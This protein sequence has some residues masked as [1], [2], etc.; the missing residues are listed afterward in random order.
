MVSL[1]QEYFTVDKKL[2][3]K[4]ESLIGDKK[5]LE[6]ILQISDPTNAIGQVVATALFLI[7]N[8]FESSKKPSYHLIADTKKFW[9]PLANNFGM[10]KVRYFLEDKLFKFLDNK[11]YSLIISLIKK[12]QRVQEKLFENIAGI[13]R[14]HLNQKSLKK[15]EILSRQKNAFG[16]FDKMK[17]KKKNINHITDFFAFRILVNTKKECYQ[18]LET[19]HKLWPKYPDRFKDY[20][21][22]PKPNFYQALHTT[23]FCLDCNVVEFQIRTYKMDYTAKYGAANH[24]LYKIYREKH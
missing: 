13:L 2:L 3:K 23:V 14:H 10:W 24:A 8:R 20:I 9:I 16:I 4:A 18:A 11:N 17:L 15:Y 12:K 5:K 22:N 1:P 6:E 7:K 19:L 21:E